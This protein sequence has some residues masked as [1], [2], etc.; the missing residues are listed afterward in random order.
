MILLFCGPET[1]VPRGKVNCPTSQSHLMLESRQ[2]NPKAS[3]LNHAALG[4]SL[5]LSFVLPP[6]V[7]LLLQDRPRKQKRHPS[8]A[9][10]TPKPHSCL[11]SSP[12]MRIPANVNR[13][14]EKKL[15]GTQHV[16]LISDPWPTDLDS[17]R[18]Q[19]V[20]CAACVVGKVTTRDVGWYHYSQEKR[21]QPLT[22]FETYFNINYQRV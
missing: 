10:L 5:W 2:K 9:C 11:A 15:F 6:F 3:P 8:G 19:E 1:E 7:T 20:L 13:V 12:A 18:P 14:Q 22:V 17:R 16:R 4:D 21:C